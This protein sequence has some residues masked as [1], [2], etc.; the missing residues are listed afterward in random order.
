ML[1]K[2]ASFRIGGYESMDGLSTFRVRVEI[3]F[4]AHG[5]TFSNTGVSNL[6]GVWLLF[7]PQF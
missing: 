3:N 2:P 5:E 1:D 4:R 7:T 6:A